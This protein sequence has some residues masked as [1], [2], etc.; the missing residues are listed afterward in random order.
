MQIVRAKENKPSGV[1]PWSAWCFQRNYA[2][3]WV[4]TAIQSYTLPTSLSFM[5][6]MSCFLLDKTEAS[7]P[8]PINSVAEMSGAMLDSF[9]YLTPREE[10]RASLVVEDITSVANQ[11]NPSTVF[12]DFCER[13]QVTEDKEQQLKNLLTVVRTGGILKLEERDASDLTIVIRTVDVSL[14]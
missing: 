7:S 8:D 12:P 11:A 10:R 5:V 3:T 9:V 14:R 2:S 4:S 6:I 13:Y 1:S